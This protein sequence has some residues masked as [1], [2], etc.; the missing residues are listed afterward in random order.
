[1]YWVY[2]VLFIVIVFVPDIIIGDILYVA[3]EK[4]EEIMI[5][6]LGFITVL[7][8][9]YQEKR[10][11][12]HFQ[13]KSRIQREFNDASHDLAS[14]YSYI[15]EVNRKLDILRGISLRL[16]ETPNLSDGDAESIFEDIKVAINVLTKTNNFVMGFADTKT[17]KLERMFFG[18]KDYSKKNTFLNQE[19]LKNKKKIVKKEQNVVVFS[20]RDIDGRVAFVD[21]RYNG[22]SIPEDT[23]LI[24]MLASQALF[25]FVCSSGVVN[26]K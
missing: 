8:F 11:R 14:S 17:G 23:E 21:F 5:F 26:K 2:L 13:E 22:A 7:I 19:I 25:L 12:S 10:F 16:I 24:Q 1:M 9:I 18:S 3:E 20:D 6:I 4:A 15:G